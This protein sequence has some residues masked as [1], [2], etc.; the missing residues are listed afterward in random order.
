MVNWEHVSRPLPVLSLQFSV[1]TVQSQDLKVESGVEER[2][3]SFDF[4]LMTED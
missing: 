3:C 2:S 4:K 1:K